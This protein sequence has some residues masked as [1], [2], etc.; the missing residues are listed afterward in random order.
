MP[1]MLSASSP[2]RRAAHL[3]AEL[4]LM[5]TFRECK[6][7]PFLLL[8]PPRR[9]FTFCFREYHRDKAFLCRV[10]CF[11][12]SPFV[13]APCMPPFFCALR[14]QGRFFGDRR[15]YEILIAFYTPSRSELSS[16]FGLSLCRPARKTPP[17]Y[18][19]CFSVS[20]SFSSR[21]REDY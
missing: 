14:D 9:G 16:D 18:D 21:S 15:G 12:F 3:R 7:Y 8:P 4:P 13:L 10:G 17:P 2:F 11:H 5:R 1:P 6:S 19:S 20:A